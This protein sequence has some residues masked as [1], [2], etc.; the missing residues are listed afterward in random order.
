MIGTKQFYSLEH[1][2]V[3]EKDQITQV[4]QLALTDQL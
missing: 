2:D 4:T 3:K 1:V